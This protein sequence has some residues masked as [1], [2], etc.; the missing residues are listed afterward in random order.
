VLTA[1]LAL[2]ALTVLLGPV[3]ALY[4]TRALWRR[5]RRR[6]RDEA[7]G[8]RVATTLAA[9]RGEDDYLEWLA[10]QFTREG[11]EP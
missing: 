3:A 6:S 11:S 10:E 1:E 2:I 7:F 8:Q 4:A 9:C 5:A